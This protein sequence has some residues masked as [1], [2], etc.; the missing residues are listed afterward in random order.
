M[1]LFSNL[2]PYTCAS[3]PAKTGCGARQ[4][5]VWNAGR[6]FAVAASTLL[7]SPS[8]DRR[9]RVGPRLFFAVS[10]LNESSEDGGAVPKTNSTAVTAV[11]AAKTSSRRSTVLVIYVR[12]CAPVSCH[13]P[14]RV[15]YLPTCNALRGR[16]VIDFPQDA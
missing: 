1:V 3:R 4:E 16:A 6:A 11:G 13:R 8:Q 10:P 14:D 2:P 12:K 9:R 7:L 15:D 5:A